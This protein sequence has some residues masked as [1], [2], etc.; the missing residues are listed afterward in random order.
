MRGK[1]NGNTFEVTHNTVFC[2]GRFCT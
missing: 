2:C 1:Q